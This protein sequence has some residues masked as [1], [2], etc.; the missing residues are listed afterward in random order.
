LQYFAVDSFALW[1]S[2]Y[3]DNPGTLSGFMCNPNS[4]GT[5]SVQQS[6]QWHLSN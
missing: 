6:L 4:I 5:V 2:A 1:F 3:L